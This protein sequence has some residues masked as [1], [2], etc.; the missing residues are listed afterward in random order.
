MRL[1]RKD[2]HIKRQKRKKCWVEFYI[3][4]R[5]EEGFD[6]MIE[7]QTCVVKRCQG[8]CWAALQQ[9]NNKFYH[10]AQQILLTL[11]ILFVNASVFFY[12]TCRL[13]NLS[14]SVRGAIFLYL[15]RITAT[16]LQR[17]LR[18]VVDLLKVNFQQLLWFVSHS[19]LMDR[20][21]GLGKA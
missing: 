21:V 7:K 1:F 5:R 6:R 9:T 11:Y 16:T 2:L 14:S 19:P 15:L 13:T 18:D 10:M 12:L 17:N 8:S 4:K 3:I 20:V